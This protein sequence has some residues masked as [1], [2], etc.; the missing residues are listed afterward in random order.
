MAALLAWPPAAVDRRRVVL[1]TALPFV[2]V[3]GLM[4]KN[5]V[6]FGTF[7]LSSWAGMNL[8]RS[9]SPLGEGEPSG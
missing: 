9:L 2:V 7:S 1:V 3:L 8:S 4:T 5:Q 6:R